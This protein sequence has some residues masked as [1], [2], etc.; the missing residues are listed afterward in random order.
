MHPRVFQIHDIHGSTKEL[1][2]NPDTACQKLQQDA[3]INYL[4]RKRHLKGRTILANG[5]NF[6][7]DDA[8]QF[9]VIFLFEKRKKFLLLLNYAATASNNNNNKAL[10]SSNPPKIKLEYT[11]NTVN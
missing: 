8:L 9:N 5:K 2:N 7:D 4:E 10:S 3:Y 11:K 1:V 6:D